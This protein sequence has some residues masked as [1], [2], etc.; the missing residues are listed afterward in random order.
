[1]SLTDDT[2]HLLMSASNSS[3]LA[4]SK[5]MLVT[6]DTSQSGMSVLP[7]APQPVPP[8]EQQFPPDGTASRQLF[9]AVCSAALLV[10]GAASDPR[11]KTPAMKNSRASITRREREANTISAWDP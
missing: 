4:K 8:E 6:C 3:R 5:T 11:T 9:T 10:K 7:A 2:S 1:M